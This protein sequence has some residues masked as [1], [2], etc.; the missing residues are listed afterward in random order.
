MEAFGLLLK[1]LSVLLTWRP[2]V[3]DGGMVL[4]IFVGC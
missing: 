1:R 3:I 4:G 2:C